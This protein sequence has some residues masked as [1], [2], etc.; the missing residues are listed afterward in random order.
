MNTNGVFS[1]LSLSRARAFHHEDP[2][3][4]AQHV[5]E[6]EVRWCLMVLNNYLSICFLFLVQDDV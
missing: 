3:F 6:T 5:K 2:I 4:I 1:P